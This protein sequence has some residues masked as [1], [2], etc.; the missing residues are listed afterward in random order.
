MMTSSRSYEGGGGGGR[1]PKMMSR[2]IGV[3]FAK[4]TRTPSAHRK[5]LT[6]AEHR[7]TLP[8]SCRGA[9]GSRFNCHLWGEMA[10]PVSKPVF[11]FVCFVCFSFSFQCHLAELHQHLTCQKRNITQTETIVQKQQHKH[12]HKVSGPPFK[13]SKP[14]T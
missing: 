5:T 7:D 8:S 3:P 9:S 4:V 11:C 12:K 2:D 6:V 13:V 14:N 10:G 1:I